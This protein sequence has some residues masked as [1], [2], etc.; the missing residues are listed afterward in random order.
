MKRS[1]ALA[2]M[3][4][5]R[6]AAQAPGPG[7]IAYA[8]AINDLSSEDPAVRLKTVKLLKVAAY[9]E[10]AVPLA[11]LIADPQETV[12]L[13]A[14]AAEL[15]IFLAGEVAGQKDGYPV[16]DKRRPLSPEA[17]FALG[18]DGLSFRPVPAEVLNALRTAA[19][20]DRPR[21][22]LDAL[23]AFG[24]LGYQPAG[25]PRLDLLRASATNLS[26]ALTAHETARRVAAARVIACVF[27]KRAG[28]DP[29]DR[30]IG[31]ALLAALND[32]DRVVRTAAMQALGAVKDERAV[33]P[34]TELVTAARGDT[35][36]AALDAL[37]HIASVSSAS[38]FRA[39]LSVK[40]V[41]AR[42]LAVEAL[43]R[44]GDAA[45]LADIQSALESD[46]TESV[47]LAVS[48]AATM[49]SGASIDPIA[50]SLVAARLHDQAI[51]YLVE[52]APGR[53]TLFARQVLDPDTRI[54]FEVAGV[55]L[56]SGDPRALALV[57]P[58]GRDK[59]PAVALLAGRAVARMRSML[60][61]VQTLPAP[62]APPGP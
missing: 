47:Q 44:L 52:I 29:I 15:N 28:D 60:P 4:T 56:R 32:K 37:A 42:M 40:S 36:E 43:A 57:E 39:Q 8:D 35:A 26:S 59:D 31:D 34:L 30:S 16:V 33:P 27:E 13:E 7:P 22:A 10:A 54:R 45:R 58:L 18:A 2:L 49:L 62:A 1:G 12:Q 6:L 55:F 61:P 20:G 17:A 14:I 24:A 3:L 11:P 9:P 38:L 51:R 53:E 46:R 25:A 5:A 21:V 48:F 19:A 41:H 50:E 23:Y